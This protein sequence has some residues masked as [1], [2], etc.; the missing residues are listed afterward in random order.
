MC[1]WSSHL[2]FLFMIEKRKDIEIKFLKYKNSSEVF[3]DKN[4]TVGYHSIGF[5]KK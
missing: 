3:G 2:V 4:G 1:G 5:I